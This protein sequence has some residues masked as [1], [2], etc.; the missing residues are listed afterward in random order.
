MRGAMATV[1]LVLTM[2]TAHAQEEKPP[3][4]FWK[5]FYADVEKLQPPPVEYRQFSQSGKLTT[6]LLDRFDE[7][8]KQYQ[9]NPYVLITGFSIGVWPFSLTMDFQLKN[10]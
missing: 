3:E 9:D 5:K 8:R 7:F 10:P 2:S 6:Y 1:L 4:E